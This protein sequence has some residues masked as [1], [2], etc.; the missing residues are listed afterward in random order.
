M[1]K[2]RCC[3]SV[4]WLFKNISL[5][6]DNIPEIFLLASKAERIF[7]FF[8]SKLKFPLFPSNATLWLAVNS[9]WNWTSSARCPFIERILCVDRDEVVAFESL[10]HLLLPS[11]HVYFFSNLLLQSQRISKLNGFGGRKKSFIIKIAL[12]K[13]LYEFREKAL[14]V[15]KHIAAVSIS[16]F[17][18]KQTSLLVNSAGEQCRKKEIVSRRCREQVFSNGTKFYFATK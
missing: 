2:F 17:T 3:R 7:Y 10:F 16:R 6:V 11:I 13:I 12:N 14:R 9:V 18:W 5:V 8:L 15:H 1:C 4:C